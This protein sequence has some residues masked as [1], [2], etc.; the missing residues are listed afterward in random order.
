[1][2]KDSERERT[3]HREKERAAKFGTRTSRRLP[4]M[5]AELAQES[6]PAQEQ[7]P[8]VVTAPPPAAEPA[9]PAP[10]EPRQLRLPG[11]TLPAVTVLLVVSSLAA[12][13]GSLYHGFA[14]MDYDYLLNNS[15]L[16]HYLLADRLVITPAAGEGGL[17]V[18][19]P[20]TMLSYLASYQ[21]WGANAAGY[22][23]DSLTL[24][25]LCS[26]LVYVLAYQLFGRNLPAVL[27]ALLFSLHPI[28]AETVDLIAGRS[29]LLVTFWGLLAAISFFI[30]RDPA[31]SA[32]QHR[33]AGGCCYLFLA[34]AMLSKEMALALPLAFLLWEVLDSRGGKRPPE[35]V[36]LYLPLA[37]MMVVFLALHEYVL[38]GVATE[39]ASWPLA[40]LSLPGLMSQYLGHLLWPFAGLPF[41]RVAAANTV[42]AYL[43][44]LYFLLVG[45]LAA[46]LWRLG[47]TRQV[48]AWA[49]MFT[50]LTLA[51]LAPLVH[52]YPALL[53]ERFLYLPSVGVCL[54]L[55]Y[56]GAGAMRRLPRRRYRFVAKVAAAALLAAFAAGS[57]ARTA[58]WSNEA[59]VWQRVVAR[60]P[61]SSAARFQLGNAYFNQGK[62]SQA[63]GSYLQA[64]ELEPQARYFY[65]LGNGLLQMDLP[66]E[67]IEAYQQALRRE[68]RYAECYHNLGTAYLLLWDLDQAEAAFRTA[69]GLAPNSLLGQASTEAIKRVEQMRA[70]KAA[71]S[72]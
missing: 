45:G 51:S 61:A 13:F 23:S 25:L 6:K 24:H 11:P 63:V 41:H 44:V 58:A 66:Y 36:R 18:W 34:L 5:E 69:A 55:G 56:L 20:L 32:N 26:I 57:A 40:L 28:H 9:P 12:F 48:P 65:N 54:F 53:S 33:L 1:M 67:A 43:T 17:P 71:R 52:R 72:R 59:G 47:R 16:R 30:R 60:Y 3:V 14:W 21:T 22:H 2:A 39:R 15:L 38:A 49:G 4:D 37:G 62:L 7:A 50:L 10:P 46:G 35:W 19:R 8:V 31:V 29:D 27:A 70:E 64:A 42:P 68:P